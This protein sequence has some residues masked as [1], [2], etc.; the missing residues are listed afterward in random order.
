MEKDSLRMV[1]KILDPEYVDLEKTRVRFKLIQESGIES[2]A[3]LTVPNNKKRGV[4][5][6]WDRI[7]DEFDI[8]KMRQKRNALESEKIKHSRHKEEKKKTEDKVLSLRLLFNKK[9]K[10]LEIPFIRDS[11]SETKSAIRRAPSI[12]ILD[13][14][15]A[16]LTKKFISENNMSF[17]DYLDYL[18]D[19]EELLENKKV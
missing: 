15:V 14:I 2:I 9:T 17:N 18:D 6:Y 4:N 8:E 10:V 12:E 3:E 19:L 5:K 13:F 1:E 16:E 11:D 7:M